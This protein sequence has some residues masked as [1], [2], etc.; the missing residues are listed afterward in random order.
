MKYILIVILI[1]LG[2]IFIKS[3]VRF[4]LWLIDFVL[5]NLFYVI[6]F[7]FIILLFRASCS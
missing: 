1:L 4:F 5:K 2:T 7:V 6:V 3:I